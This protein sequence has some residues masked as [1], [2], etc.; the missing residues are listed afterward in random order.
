MIGSRW[1]NARPTRPSPGRLSGLTDG[2]LAFSTCSARSESLCSSNSHSPT[3]S[4]DRSA[5]ACSTTS[6]ASPS[7][8]STPPIATPIWCSASK[9]PA[10]TGSVRSAIGIGALRFSLLFGGSNQPEAETPAP[11]PGVTLFLEP[12]D[13]RGVGHTAAFADGGECVATI[14]A[15]ELVE[16]GQNQPCTTGAERMAQCN[17]TTVHVEPVDADTQFLLPRQADGRERLV[18]FEDVD[19]VRRHPSALQ[20]LARGRNRA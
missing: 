8:S 16:R 1:T 12:F 7:G 5:R 10:G 3:E 2:M 6:R 20:H 18:D 14:A 15:L 13:N 19:V 9:T 11:P 17:R 4:A